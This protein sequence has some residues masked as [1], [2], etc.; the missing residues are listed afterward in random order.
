MSTKRRDFLKAAGLTSLGIL[1]GGLMVRADHVSDSIETTRIQSGRQK[2]NMCGYRAPKID[3]VRIGFIGVGNRGSGAVYRMNHIDGVEIKAIADIRRNVAEKSL[4]NVSGPAPTIYADKEDEWKKLCDRD[5]IDLVY[6]CTPWHLHTPMAVYAMKAGKHVAIEVP[7]AT[8]MEECWQL[9]ET[10]EAT[11]KHCMMLENCC[12]DFFELMTLNMARQGV[13][14]EILHGEGAYIHDLLNDNFGKTS[15]YDMWRLKENYRDG[16]L[17]PTHGLGPVCQIM[18]VNRGDQ[19]DYLTSMSGNDFSMSAKA[20]ELA[21]KD[22]FYQ[23]FA[24]KG[25]RGNMNTTTIRT[26]KGRT[27]MLQ[28]DVSSP[29]PYSRIHI[30]SGTKGYAQKWPEPGKIAFG[31][32]WIS[33]DE[34]KKLEE[35]YTPE[36]V[37]K[38]GEMAKKVGGHGGMDFMMDWRLVDCLRNGLSLD[39]DVYDAALWSAIAP[40]SEKSVKNRSNSVDVPDFTRGAWKSNPLLELTLKGGGSTGVKA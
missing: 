27:I 9:V 38:V 17:Y 20:K 2:F 39:Q 23:Q 4:K 26:H 35:Q 31:H 3:K 24:N 30:V 40:L 12:Y 37:L 1:G 25:F 19:M 33:A 16:N 32:D 13:F 36:I 29:R 22:D 28:H 21:A 5:D 11:K 34:M 15:Y 7:A 14:G 18:G 10:S 8:T 6:I